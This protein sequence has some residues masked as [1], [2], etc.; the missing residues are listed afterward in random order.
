M[1]LSATVT[2]SGPD[3]LL[4]HGASNDHTRWDPVLP[5]LGKHFTC[6]ALDRRGRG[7]SS[8]GLGYHINKEIADT[9]GAIRTLADQGG[10]PVD[11]V[12]H[13][14]GAICALEAARGNPRLRRLI[15]YEPPLPLGEPVPP[16]GVVRELE[17]LA[18]AGRKEDI[19]L[20]FMRKAVRMPEAEIKAAMAHPS[21]PNRVAAAHTI[22][23]ELAAL[24]RDYRFDPAKFAD[25][26]VPTLV[27]MGGESP[28]FLKNACETLART[29]KGAKLCTLQGQQHVA[30]MMAPE[31]FSKEVLTFLA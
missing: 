6:Y 2:G 27:M 15:L 24:E 9:D 13:S 22:P 29:L 23:R 31:L 14:Y 7:N 16:P 30:M 1:I 28:A 26:N 17:D 8:D 3:L 5:I 11:V 25:W 20:T 10:P 12:G 21:W 4:I 19:V 18:A